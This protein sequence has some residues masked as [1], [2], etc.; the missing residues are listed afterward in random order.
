MSI[1]ALIDALYHTAVD[2]QNTFFDDLSAFPAY[3]QAVTEA[4]HRF[5]A[6]LLSETLT[7]A[8]RMIRDSGQRKENYTVQRQVSRSLISVVGDLSFRH[9]CYRDRR[10]GQY[11]FLL[12][13]LLRL[14]NR[15]RMTSL[16]EA[17][18]LDE[19]EVY[20]YQHAADSL[21]TGNQSVTKT[22]VMN[23][24]HAI[25]ENIPEE[26]AGEAAQEKKRCE[27][28]YIEADEDHIHRQ[29]SGEDGGMIG[30]LIYLY[31]GKR[32]LCKGRRTL[33]SPFYFG[34]LYAGAEQNTRLWD[35]VEKYIHDHYDQD[36]LRTVYLISDGGT[37]I[38]TGLERVCKSKSVMDKYHV[39]RYINRTSRLAEDETVCKQ[40]FY[41]AICKNRPQF[42]RELFRQ[43]RSRHLEEPSALRALEESQSYFENHW[44]AIERTYRD[45]H[46]L[47]SSTEGHVSHVL[48]ERMSSR[49]MGWSERGS[50]RMCK[51]RCFVRNHGRCSVPFLVRSRRE[52]ACSVRE[53]AATG[54]GVM[55]SQ[56][57]RERYSREQRQNFVYIEKLQAHVEESINIRKL[58]A[59]RNQIGSI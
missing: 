4:C 25:E 24:V 1:I 12:D 50:D 19:A 23:K 22:T 36:Y 5:A 15:E 48:S 13:E 35:L 33:L 44:R 18:L 52:R 20:S 55:I 46:V 53:T 49:P 30:K 27:Y 9:T 10:T 14:P 59:I 56:E 29:K 47:G 32:E 8:D 37:W 51:L 11:R 3:E 39:M 58:L 21:R 42:I 54:M 7:E 34:G 31:E 45:E 26:F 16:A 28:L 38:R 57:Q 6:G 17:K 2:A 43:L 41:R 40:E